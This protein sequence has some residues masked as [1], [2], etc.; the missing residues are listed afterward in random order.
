MNLKKDTRCQF[1]VIFADKDHPITIQR[2]QPMSIYETLQPARVAIVSERRN[3]KILTVTF[4]GID[5]Y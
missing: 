1:S 2:T 5:I 4:I 3:V